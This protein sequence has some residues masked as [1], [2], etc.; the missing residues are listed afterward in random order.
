MF[1][2]RMGQFAF[3]PRVDISGPITLLKVHPSFVVMQVQ[4]HVRIQWVRVLCS[5][6]SVLIIFHYFGV[7]IR[8]A[9]T[10]LGTLMNIVYPFL[11]FQV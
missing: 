10:L 1:H 7:W 8:I 5:S 9:F 11:F 4:S 6:V 2:V 3:F